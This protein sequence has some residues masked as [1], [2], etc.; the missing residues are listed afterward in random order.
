MIKKDKYVIAVDMGG[1][2]L[3]CAV[4]DKDCRIVKSLTRPSKAH[5]KSDKVIKNIVK[6]INEI[7]RNFGQGTGGIVGMGIG[8][9]GYVNAEA[10]VLHKAANLPNMKDVPLAG[11]L[12]KK[13]NVPVFIGH[14]IDMATLAEAHFGAGQ[15][16]K[17]VVCITI[18]T[19]I[20]MGMIFNG[21]LYRGS[22]DGAGNLGHMVVEKDVHASQIQNKAILEKIAAGPA[23]REKAVEYINKGNESV[24]K[25]MCGGDLEKIDARMVFQAAGDGDELCK[26][27][28]NETTQVLGI[29]I[30]NVINMLSPE[31]III[32][33]GVALAGDLLFRAVIN[34]VKKY[35]YNFP[36]VESRIVPS[37]LGDSAILIGTAYTV[38]HSMSGK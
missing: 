2:N 11:I 22:N 16:K 7:T 31:I 36:D 26:R 18:G 5:L 14:D 38:W 17:H 33:G 27:I 24:L 9:P 6:S 12:K 1:T 25:E 28:V 30:A 23:I 34:S 29:G 37:Q 10:G 4:V 3:K 8:L 19:G 15:G 20:G 35:V 13:F 32:G 21:R